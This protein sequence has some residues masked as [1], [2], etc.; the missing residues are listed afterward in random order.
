MAYNGAKYQMAVQNPKPE[1][2][3]G[4]AVK[5]LMLLSAK[6]FPNDPTLKTGFH[7]PLTMPFIF[8]RDDIDE[9][10]FTELQKP[11]FWTGT[12]QRIAKVSPDT[13]QEYKGYS[14]TLNDKPGGSGEERI[15]VFVEEQTGLPLRVRNINDKTQA[16][17][18]EIKVTQFLPEANGNPAFPLNVEIT[19]NGSSQP[20]GQPKSSG[21]GLITVEPTSISFAAPDAKR[22]TVPLSSVEIAVENDTIVHSRFPV[23]APKPAAKTPSKASKKPAAKKTSKRKKPGR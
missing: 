12:Q 9:V 20:G 21:T 18:G 4:H 14:V 6:P 22:F 11:G 13:W 8:T 1:M 23:T 2:I 7:L 5:N 15:E 10:N 19:G 16:V 17:I 3:A